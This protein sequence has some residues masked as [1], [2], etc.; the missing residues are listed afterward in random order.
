[1]TD[2]PATPRAFARPVG[3]KSVFVPK[4]LDACV[5]RR[6][7]RRHDFSDLTEKPLLWTTT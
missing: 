3:H 2:L 6:L 7:C 4:S 1:M 5:H